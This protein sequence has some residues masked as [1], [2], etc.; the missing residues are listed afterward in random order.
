M[1]PVSP[2]KSTPSCLLSVCS[3]A[4]VVQFDSSQACY[5]SLLPAHTRKGGKQS[6]AYLQSSSEPKH[7]QPT[8]A[9]LLVLAEPPRCS[10]TCLPSVSRRCPT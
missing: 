6:I 7:S 1:I 10:S 8:A 5:R 3:G 4:A 2:H 9:F